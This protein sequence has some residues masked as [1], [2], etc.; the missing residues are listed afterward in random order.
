VGVGVGVGRALGSDGGVDDGD[1]GRFTMRRIT[2][3]G[4][5]PFA[6]SLETNKFQHNFIVPFLNFCIKC[7]DCLDSNV[8][9]KPV[10]RVLRKAWRLLALFV[11]PREWSC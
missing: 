3:P 8:V 7:C 2:L 9:L 11:V 6:I 10:S 5:K 1:G 4:G